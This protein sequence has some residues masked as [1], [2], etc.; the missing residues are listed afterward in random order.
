MAAPYGAGEATADLVRLV[1]ILAPG[2]ATN[3]A[4][5]VATLGGRAGRGR[6]GKWGRLKR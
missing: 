6:K 4:A 1:K 3:N 5:Y 2:V